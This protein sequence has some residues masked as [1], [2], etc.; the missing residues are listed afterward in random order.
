MC[1]R[2]AR[3][4]VTPPT[5]GSSRF[6]GV[7]LAV[8]AT[9]EAQNQLLAE[10]PVEEGDHGVVAGLL[11]RRAE[12]GDDDAPAA[13]AG[14]AEQAIPGLGRVPGLD[15]VG[16]GIEVEEVVRRRIPEIVEHRIDSVDRELERW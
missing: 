5:L 10:A 11:G 13:A 3:G 2:S 15:P 12:D 8:S 7:L 16:A 1:G 14:R 4:S 6:S 9:Q